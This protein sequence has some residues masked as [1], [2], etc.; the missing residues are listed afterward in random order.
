MNIFHVLCRPMFYT[1]VMAITVA[2]I[3]GTVHNGKTKNTTFRNHGKSG[4]RSPIAISYETVDIIK[5]YNNQTAGI[6]KVSIADENGEI[7]YDTVVRPLQDVVDYRT[8][9]TGIIEKELYKGENFYTVRINILELISWRILIGYKIGDFLGLMKIRHPLHLLRDTSYFTRCTLIN[10]DKNTDIKFLAKE[11][12]DIDLKN[13]HDTQEKAIATMKL[14]IKFQYQWEMYESDNHYVSSIAYS[15]DCEMVKGIN[16]NNKIVDIAVRVSIVDFNCNIVYDRFFKPDKPVT[17]Y[18]SNITGLYKENFTHAEYLC[19]SI[20]KIGSIIKGN[21]LVGHELSHHLKFLGIQ[22]PFSLRRDTSSF[23]PFLLVMAGKPAPT[24][25]DLAQVL[26]NRTIQEKYRDT[27][28]NAITAMKLY[29]KY[30]YEWD[31]EIRSMYQVYHAHK[32][33]QG[34]R[35]ESSPLAINYGRILANFTDHK[36]KIIGRVTVVDENKSCIYDKYIKPKS[37]SSIV[38]CYTKTTGITFENLRNATSKPQ[39]RQELLNIL[40]DRIIVGYN[41]NYLFSNF[42]LK[43]DLWNQRDISLYRHFFGSLNTVQTIYKITKQ[44]LKIKLHRNASSTTRASLFIDLYLKYKDDWDIN[45]AQMVTDMKTNELTKIIIHKSNEQ[46]IGDPISLQCPTVVEK[47]WGYM[48]HNVLARIVL[49]DKD[50]NCVYDKYIK[51]HPNRPIIDYRTNTTGILPEHLATGTKYHTAVSEISRLIQNKIIVGE[52]IFKCIRL[53]PYRTINYKTVR[54]ICQFSI[55]NK[56]YKGLFSLNKLCKKYM[57]FILKNEIDSVERSRA[58]MLIY[59]RYA[60]KWEY[61]I[62]KKIKK[63]AITKNQKF[64]TTFRASNLPTPW[65]NRSKVNTF[66]I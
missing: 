2:V 51:P 4:L 50:G 40:E 35:R 29:V 52:Q 8:N 3:K 41:L 28:E 42:R 61:E 44:F 23:R 62:Q 9:I 27:V 65:R 54:D 12:L 57:G 25:K 22:H 48:G 13:I 1:F 16:E 31:T 21:I 20:Y 7:I 33:I 19:Y 63:K 39:V 34:K 46:V 5:L 53:L 32:N 26:L 11:F 56:D 15:L 43:I 18:R 6:C 30:K 64:I 49:T 10:T 58:L 45:V 17:D 66:L 60:E 14:Y 38:D 47:S 37:L 59:K 36:V 55:F 24:L